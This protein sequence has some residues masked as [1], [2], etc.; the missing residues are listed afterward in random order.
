MP[1]CRDMTALALVIATLCGA[2]C[3]TAASPEGSATTG[4]GGIST[5]W[6]VTPLGKHLLQGQILAKYVAAGGSNGA[7]GLPITDEQAGPGGGRYTKFENGVIYWTPQT[8]AHIVAGE[9]RHVWEYD[10]G[11][12]SGPLG[13]P[14][15]DQQGITGGME[16]HFQHGTISVVNGQPH[17]LTSP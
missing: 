1:A 4:A 12:A 14:T 10:N 11:G 7:L 3:S 5:Q 2:G 9:M 8:G 17:I 15:T 6:V 16:Q 13:Y